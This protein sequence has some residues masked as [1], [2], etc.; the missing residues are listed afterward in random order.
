MTSLRGVPQATPV[1]TTDEVEMMSRT[2]GAMRW[3]AN[4]AAISAALHL[5]ALVVSAFSTEALLMLPAAI[6]YAGLAYGLLQGWRWLAYIAFIVFLIGTSFAISGIWTPGDVP[7]WIHA[8][9][10]VANGLTAAA[11]FGA[12]WK[13]PDPAV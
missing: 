12:L 13:S 11:L 8:S 2:K 3:G 1:R 5:L 7:G 10:A 4:F 9:I 6:V